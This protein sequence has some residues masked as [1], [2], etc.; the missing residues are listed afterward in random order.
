MI[1]FLIF[2]VLSVPEIKTEG[3]ELHCSLWQQKEEYLTGEPIFLRISVINTSL[4]KIWVLPIDLRFGFTGIYMSV[5]KRENVKLNMGTSFNWSFPRNPDPNRKPRGFYPLEKGDSIY[6]Y[7]FINEP[8]EYDIPSSTHRYKVEKV[9][10]GLNLKLFSALENLSSSFSLCG[11]IEKEFNIEFSIVPPEDI[12]ELELITT[13]RNPKWPFVPEKSWEEKT[14]AY[15][16]LLKEYPNSSYK[17]LAMRVLE[18]KRF[19]ESYPNSPLVY[20]IIKEAA[21]IGIQGLDIPLWVKNKSEYRRDYQESFGDFD[22]EKCLDYF[23]SFLENEKYRGT[24]LE[25]AILLWVDDV[26]KG[27]V[28]IWREPSS[29]YR[30]RPK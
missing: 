13:I 28:T 29:T 1:N 9:R 16:K 5:D 18:K 14:R 11:E 4:E 7:I 8:W 20:E 2:F 23:N 17:P 22:K 27:D 24:L 19:L 30:R 3:I 15:N 21:R 26:E 25:D 12:R 6:K 10:H